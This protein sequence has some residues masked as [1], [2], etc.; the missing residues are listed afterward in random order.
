MSLAPRRAKQNNSG[1]YCIGDGKLRKTFLPSDI[2]DVFDFDSAV[3]EMQLAAA[4]SGVGV[5]SGPKKL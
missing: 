2:N 5:F 3:D 4:C 1:Q